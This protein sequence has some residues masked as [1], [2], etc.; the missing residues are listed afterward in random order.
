MKTRT[1][2]VVVIFLAILY[3]AF[4]Q[5]ISVPAIAKIDL[6]KDLDKLYAA[7]N[8]EYFD[9]KLPRNTVI[10]WD[11]HDGTRMASTQVLPDGRF[12]IAFN[13]KYC[14]S[15]RVVRIVLKHEECHIATFSEITRDAKTEHGPRWRTCMLNL[16]Q[17]GGF[18]RELIDGL[19]YN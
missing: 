7:D 11:E 4:I 13:K 2:I 10:D 16:Y 6:P 5:H 17:V 9:D 12:H 19:T 8:S 1:K 3:F 18:K 14:L 15:E